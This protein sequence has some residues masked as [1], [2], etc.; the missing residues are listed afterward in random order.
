MN[1]PNWPLAVL[2][3]VLVSVVFL[4]LDR[5]AGLFTGSRGPIAACIVYESADATKYT[6]AQIEA[7][8]ATGRVAAWMRDAGYKFYPQVDKDIQPP[9]GKA[10]SP[11]ITKALDSAADKPL[12]ALVV[13]SADTGKNLAVEKVADSDTVL[14]TLKRLGG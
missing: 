9:K 14:D 5:L 10:L 13:W 7:M 3:L 12:P 6:A 4:P 2:G 8:A 1:K 11:A